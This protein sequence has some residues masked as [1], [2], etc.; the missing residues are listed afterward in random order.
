[1]GS[2]LFHELQMTS[3]PPGFALAVAL[4]VALELGTPT[5]VA[6]PPLLLAAPPLAPLFDPL[7]HPPTTIPA[8]ANTPVTSKSL[9][10]IVGPCI[11]S[12]SRRISFYV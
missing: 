5:A 3:E 11:L 1:M 2:P 6:L 12:P 10:L 4:A 7:E 9:R 8:P